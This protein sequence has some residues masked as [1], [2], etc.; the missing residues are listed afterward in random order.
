M[1]ARSHYET[2]GV[3]RDASSEEIKRAYRKLARTYHP[4]RNPGDG[5]AEERFKEVGKAFEVLSDPTK[6]KLYDELGD[7]AERIGY[8]PDKAET[9]RRWANQSAGRGG[10]GKGGLGIDLE[11]L[12]GGGFD[13]GFDFGGRG[14]PARE[15]PSA[16][17]DVTTRVHIG[18]EEAVKGGTRQIRLK[19]PVACKTC[20]GEGR[21]PGARPTSCAHC[22]GK[23]RVQVSQA[24]LQLAV[25]C[26][27]C[28]GTGRGEPPACSACGGRGAVEDDV[29]LDVK[30]P[31]G[32]KDGQKIRLGGQGAPGKRGGA[33]GNLLITV[34]VAEHPYL[35]REGRDLYID[36]PLTVPEALLG[37][38]IEVPT[39]EGKV[40]LKVP[41]GTQSDAKLRLRGK[42]VPAHGSDP[43]GDL[44]AVVKVR[45]PTSV[46]DPA[47]AEA[48]A[49]TL[50]GLYGA[51]VR[52]W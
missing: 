19:K 51:P 11:D 30:I 18:F 38:E 45:L 24:H 44:Y 29:R 14:R 35:R 28:S 32:V 5:D 13:A 9:Y 48:A 42:G 21:A 6:R 40:S 7:D 50:S 34:S 3:S 8:D 22:G 10:G 33:P 27:A 23:G 37:A 1:K 31:P 47:A 52:A 36:V 2:L 41:P 26:P 15:G 25:P 39:L 46:A 20:H 43:A 17:A 49:K 16:G 4:D 12:F